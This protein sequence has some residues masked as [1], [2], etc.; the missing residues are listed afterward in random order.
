[1][2]GATAHHCLNQSCPDSLVHFILSLGMMTI[3]TTP[4]NHTCPLQEGGVA[5][6]E[7]GVA[8]ATHP[9]TTAM[10]TTM[11]I[12]A[13]GIA[14]TAVVATTTPTMAMMTSRRHPAGGVAVASEALGEGR[15]QPEEDVAVSLA[16]GHPED[17]PT[18]PSE[19]VPDLAAACVA[20]EEEE[21][22][23]EAWLRRE[24]EEGYVVF[25][26]AAVAMS[27]ESAKLTGTTSQIPSVARPI[28]R[29]GARSPSPS[30]HCRA[31]SSTIT[32]PITN[33]TTRSFIRILTVSSGSKRRECLCQNGFCLGLF[34]NFN[35]PPHF[36]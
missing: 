6:V 19:A 16:E 5:G 31:A 22:E 26:A 27:E 30:S 33:P 10:T 13:T 9:T 15:R 28:I 32:T 2:S 20:P 34:F 4:P 3:T 7:T 18:S 17:V 23:Q 14:V 11:N 21:R 35:P 24:G 1:M 29:T 36:F 8:T 12:I 25:G